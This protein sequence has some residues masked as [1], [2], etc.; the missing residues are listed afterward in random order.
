VLQALLAWL[1]VRL[2]VC[3]TLNIVM[4]TTLKYF[5][6]NTTKVHYALVDSSCFVKCVETDDI[7][8]QVD[9]TWEQ[10]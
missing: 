8:T 9:V 6:K 2:M 5:R 4:R 3:I 7:Q 1:P 10:T